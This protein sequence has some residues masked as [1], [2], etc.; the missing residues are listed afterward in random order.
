MTTSFLRGHKI[1]FIDNQWVYRDTKSPTI[2]NQRPCGLCCKPD[3]KK[4]HDACLGT[5]FGVMNACCGHGI[6]GEAYVQF[7]PDHLEVGK[8]AI[9]TI[10]KLCNI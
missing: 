7:S 8:E 1:I 5:L 6:D 9:K 3:T 4:G 2:G 10:T